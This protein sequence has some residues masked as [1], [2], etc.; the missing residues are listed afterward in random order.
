[1]TTKSDYLRLELNKCQARLASCEEVIRFALD[2]AIEA[3]HGEG[4]DC[5]TCQFVR[6]ALTALNLHDA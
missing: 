6:M 3:G 1:M 4:D 2:E 5:V